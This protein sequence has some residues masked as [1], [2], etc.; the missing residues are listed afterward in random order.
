MA[1][2]STRGLEPSRDEALTEMLIA[3]RRLSDYN[4]RLLKFHVDDV[5]IIAAETQDGSLPRLMVTK[6]REAYT[7]SLR[8]FEMLDDLE[9]H[10]KRVLDAAEDKIG[11][12]LNELQETRAGLQAAQDELQRCLQGG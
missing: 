9:H 8:F 7:N 5:R 4:R 2:Q 11:D 1:A 6:S 10:L 12:L 3:L